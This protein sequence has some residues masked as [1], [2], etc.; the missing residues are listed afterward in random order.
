MVDHGHNVI[1]KFTSG[2]Q[3]LT[4]VTNFSFPRDIAIN[5]YNSKIYVVDSNGVQILNPDLSISGLFHKAQFIHPWGISCDSTGKVY[6]ADVCDNHIKVFTPEGALL[7][8]FGGRGQGIGQLHHPTYVVVDA[9]D[10]VY[11]SE[12]RNFRVSVFT[13][14]RYIIWKESSHQE[15]S[16]SQKLPTSL[17]P[18][19]LQLIPTIKLVFRKYMW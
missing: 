16:C 5:P 12:H 7:R 2:G 6:V 11:V 18:V 8:T 17:F 1:R 19:I 15:A 14:E 3:L 9:S 10:L 4:E 13:S